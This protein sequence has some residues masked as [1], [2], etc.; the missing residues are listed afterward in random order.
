[1]QVARRKPHTRKN[2]LLGF[3]F[4]VNNC[5]QFQHSSRQGVACWES[6][7]ERIS[8]LATVYSWGVILQLDSIYVNNGKAHAAPISYIQIYTT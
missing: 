8:K 2:L 7:P 6:E 1:M 3:T 5:T 4:L